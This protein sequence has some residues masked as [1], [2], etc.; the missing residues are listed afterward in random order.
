MLI[1]TDWVRPVRS[2]S[3]RWL[4]KACARLRLFPMPGR[5]RRRWPAAAPGVTQVAASAHGLPASAP[6]FGGLTSGLPLF[7]SGV[8]AFGRQFNLLQAWYSLRVD[9]LVR[10][11]SPSG[12]IKLLTACVMGWLLL[13][14]AQ[15]QTNPDLLPPSMIPKSPTVAPFQRV[16]EQRYVDLITGGAQTSLPLADVSSGALSLSVALG[17][18]YTGLQVYRPNDLVG[19]GWSLQAGGSISR[20]LG[21]QPDELMPRRRAYSPTAV[22]AGL[23]DAL[24]VKNAVANEIDVVPDVYSFQFPGGS[25]RFVVLDTAVVMLPQQPLRVRRRADGSFLIISEAGV[26]YEFSAK[27]TTQPNPNNFGNVGTYTSAWQMTRVISADN[28]DTIRLHYSRQGYTPPL[29]WAQTVGELF[30]GDNQDIA[31]RCN[32]TVGAY[33]IHNVKTLGSHIQAQYLDSITTRG[34]RLVLER[35]A[36]KGVLHRVRLL[37]AHPRRERKTITLFQSAFENSP[38]LDP[39]LRLDRVQECVAGTCLPAYRFAYEGGDFPSRQS[40]AQ[41]HWGY[42]N[43]AINNGGGSTNLGDANSETTYSALLADPVLGVRVANRRPDFTFSR[44]GALRRIWYPTG[45]T[46]VLDYEA[47]VLALDDIIEIRE[48]APVLQIATGYNPQYPPATALATATGTFRV[49][50]AGT[51]GVMLSRM[52]YW[53]NGQAGGGSN[54]AQDFDLWKI[55]PGGDSLI[56]RRTG[57]IIYKCIEPQEQ[58]LFEFELGP[59]MYRATLYCERTERNSSL[60]ITAPVITRR[61]SAPGPGI[62]VRQATTTAVGAT[63]LVRRYQYVEGDVPTGRSL[64]PLSATGEPGFERQS[65]QRIQIIPDNSAQI[66]TCPCLQ[67]SSDNTGLGNEYNRY[68]FYNTRVTE[69][70]G[71]GQGYIVHD[72]DILPSLFKEIVL[73]GRRTYRQDPQ[74]PQQ[75]Q[76]AERERHWY[77]G[78]SARLFPALRLR[79]S[80]QS[81]ATINADQYTAQGYDIWASFAPIRRSEQV[82][83][84][85]RGD[86]LVQGTHYGYRQ[87]RM[88]RKA[89]RTS[90]G[91]QV[92]T[93]RYLSDYDPALPQ[94]QALRVH[95]FNPIIETLNWRTAAAS[96]DSVLVGGRLSFYDPQWRSPAGSWSLQLGQPVVGLNA[97]RYSNGL[98]AGFKSDTRYRADDSVK[99]HPATGLLQQRQAPGAPPTAYVWGY[100]RAHVVAQVENATAAQVQAILTQPVLDRLLGPTPGTDAQ[101]RALLAPLRAQLPQARVTV[102]TYQPLVGLTSQTDPSGR[103]SFFEYDALGR[104]LRSRDE[105]GRLLVEQEYHYARP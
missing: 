8:A 36:A 56:T 28:A 105:Q 2:L 38:V 49:H 72:F 65:F 74:Q 11:D 16:D 4:S 99:Y 12:A 44:I 104:L 1:Q 58:R 39:I 32:T 76:L 78:D 96:Q 52:P 70:L 98:L 18:S 22:N 97:E 77:S 73:T 67:T 59:G 103:T 30:M 35:D 29:R 57:S 101:V 84:D 86:S 81:L 63:P 87:Q 21:G 68:V 61:T 46:T 13:P 19:L 20:Q 27:E 31:S 75:V 43:G 33:K 14:T 66:I 15:A 25:G 102:Y 26:R 82:R 54:T 23:N 91:W 60:D 41:D 24:Y 88:A 100:D 53:T 3:I 85:E 40:V 93:V 89:T 83:Y 9:E 64:L 10:S 55:L 45:G 92:S 48:S 5:D 47:N 37:G 51:V 94:V 50:F 17:Y 90:T 69:Q 7:R 42:Y 34:V 62:R 80:V 6:P 71:S 95:N 79:M